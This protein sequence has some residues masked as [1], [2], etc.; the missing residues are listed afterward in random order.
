MPEDV[1]YTRLFAV[2]DALTL[3]PNEGLSW[4]DLKAELMKLDHQVPA[5]T[6]LEGAYDVVK[7][8]G[9]LELEGE[10][11]SMAY[12]K[13]V[14]APDTCARIKDCVNEAEAIPIAMN[15]DFTWRDDEIVETSTTIEEAESAIGGPL[16]RAAVDFER[17]MGHRRTDSGS[18]QSSASIETLPDGYYGAASL[19]AR[20]W[21][22]VVSTLGRRRKLVPVSHE[23]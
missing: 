3:M 17:Q 8:A 15:D 5:D 19:R 9:I 6:A 7:L 20:A 14:E 16:R 21:A 22:N 18:T 13:G 4:T 23:A 11:T 1:F 10:A 12:P 2:C